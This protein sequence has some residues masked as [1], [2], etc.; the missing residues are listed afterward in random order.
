MHNPRI[1]PADLPAVP[2]GPL[3]AAEQHVMDQTGQFEGDA[4]VNLVR[5]MQTQQVIHVTTP[6]PPPTIV[7]VPGHTHAH[8]HDDSGTLLA[9]IL[10]LVGFVLTWLGM[11]H[12]TDQ[13]GWRCALVG[14]IAGATIGA[15][16][17]AVVD[18]VRRRFI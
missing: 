18:G 10:G 8:N 14:V 6:A 11:L 7:N 9:F 13:A 15:M 3:T 4:I 2:A 5:D 12:W 1:G 17:L 16:C